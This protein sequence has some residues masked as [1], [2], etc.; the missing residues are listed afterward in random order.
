MHFLQGK[1]GVIVQTRTIVW[2]RRGGKLVPFIVAYD[3][4]TFNLVPKDL[5][6]VAPAILC[7]QGK[8]L[9]D[10]IEHT[11]TFLLTLHGTPPGPY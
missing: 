7:E 2:R 6:Y 1:N 4:N 8:V 11:Y 10:I 9:I 3:G 5:E